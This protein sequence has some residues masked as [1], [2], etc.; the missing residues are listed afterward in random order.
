MQS[1]YIPKK[2]NTMYVTVKIPIQNKTTKPFN[3]MTLRIKN[4]EI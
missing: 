4:M 2:T 3:P 1:N